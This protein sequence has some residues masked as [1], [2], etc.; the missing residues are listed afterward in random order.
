MDFK[1]I[2]SNAFLVFC[3]FISFLYFRPE[4]KFKIENG[5]YI[6]VWVI[7]VIIIKCKYFIRNPIS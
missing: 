5:Q 3:L 2:I 1:L 4:Y 6:K 7:F